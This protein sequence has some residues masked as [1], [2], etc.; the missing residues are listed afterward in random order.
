MIRIPLLV[1]TVMATVVMALT[2]TAPATAADS[3][4]GVP[5]TTQADGTRACRGDQAHRIPTW[6]GVPLDADIYLPPAGA[7]GPFPLLVGLHG[8]AGDKSSSPLNPSYAK[9][10]YVVLN[11]SAR[12]FGMSCGVVISRTA[13]ACTKGWSHLADVRYEPRDTQYLAGLLADAGLVD[14]R[15]IGVTGT[16]YGAGQSL[17]LATLKDRTVTADY[18]LVPWTS[19][20]GK[21]MAIAAAAPNWAWSSLAS[22]LVPNGHDLD[23]SLDNDYGSGAAIGTPKLSYV[24]LLFGA[25]SAAGFFAPP[26]TDFKSDANAWVT[27]FLLGDPYTDYDRNVIAEIQAHHSP[28]TIED[29]VPPAQREAPAPVFANTA[30]TDDLLPPTEQLVQRGRVLS[31]YPNAE[32]DLLF[33]DGAGHPRAKIAGG[34]TPGLGALQHA[35]FDRLLKGG[36]GRPLGIRT[37]TQGCGSSTITGPFDTTGWNAQ[38]PG[39]VRYTAPATPRTIGQLA[40]PATGLA[41]DPVVALASPCILVPA[42]DDPLAATYRLPA[43][44]GAGYTI[45]GSPTVVATIAASVPNAQV[46]ARLW[47]VGPDGRQAF[48]TRVAYRPRLNDSGPQVFQLHPNGWHIAPGHVVKLELTGADQPYV[49]QSNAPF[50]ATVSRLSLRLPVREHP[51]TGQA[52]APAPL[53]DRDGRPLPAAKL[54]ATALSGPP[55]CTSRRRIVVHVRGLRHPIVRVGGD[56]VP[57]RHGRAVIDLRGRGAGTLVIRTTGRTAAGRRVLRVQRVHPCRAA[58]KPAGS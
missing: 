33:S 31:R 51:G 27:N 48:I 43:A 28:Y 13:A 11:Y 57:V 24:G 38:H 21:P 42:A 58:K 45:L 16:S 22:M 36:P 40:N 52:L 29:L 54:A 8:F 4:L 1:A 55:A 18:R 26:D 32:Y 23:Y 20:M 50:S 56:R 25:G 44:T 7:K 49:R 35:F 9:D 12:G 30:W 15:R 47:D 3:V 6:D 14:G 17:M 10:G 46:D 5:C 41:V 19:P 39:E 53:L 2:S 37:F 34:N